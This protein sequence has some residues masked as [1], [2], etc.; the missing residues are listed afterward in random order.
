MSDSFSSRKTRPIAHFLSL[1]TFLVTYYQNL[2]LK[3]EKYL[4]HCEKAELV[5]YFLCLYHLKRA[6]ESLF[7]FKYRKEQQEFYKVLIE[8][9]YTT[10]FSAQLAKE[11]CRH[12]FKVQLADEFFYPVLIILFFLLPV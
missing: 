8:V 10:T 3:E 6:F 7:V 1:Y 5:I 4:F 11:L 2:R 12:S 9:T